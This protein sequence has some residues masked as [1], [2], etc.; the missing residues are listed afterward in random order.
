MTTNP[1]FNNFNSTAEQSLL[2][3]LVIESIKIHGIQVYYLPKTL[4]GFDKIYGE[5]STMEFNRAIPIEMYMTNIDSFGGDGSFFSKFNIEIRDQVTLAVATKRFLE[6]IPDLLRPNEG[7]LVYFPL[8]NRIF[9]I[10]YA[11]EKALFFPLGKLN[12]FNLTMEVF[13]Y[14]NERFNTGIP[15]IDNIER[16]Y[17]T[18]SEVDGIATDDNLSITDNNGWSIST[19]DGDDDYDDPFSDNT[20]IQEESDDLIDFSE[21]DPWSE[22][23]Y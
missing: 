16:T 10:H 3:N 9:R 13:E 2:E 5:D 4:T 8:N 18:S 22:G 20:A 17:S 21:K 6:A 14:S 23:R 12:T 7:D 19:D 15:L 11:D 1:F